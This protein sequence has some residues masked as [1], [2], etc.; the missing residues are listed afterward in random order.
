MAD[1][2]VSDNEIPPVAHD[3]ST[4]GREHEFVHDPV[5][6]AEIVAE[7]AD[8]PDG[9]WLDC[10]LGG[11]G[12]ARAVLEAHGGLRLI[13]LDRDPDALAAAGERLADLGDRAELHRCRFDA[14]DRALDDAGVD[15]LAGFLFDLGVSSPQ[16]DVAERG[17]SFRH[18]GP[19]DMRMDPDG[20]RTA[21]DLV[22]TAD[23]GTLARVLSRYGDERFAGR[24]ASAIIDHRPITRTAE[25]AEI[26]VQAIPAAARRTG[27]HPAKRT[28]QAI[29]IEINDELTVLGP[30]LDAAIDRLDT[31]GR[32]LV[33]TYH[34]GED[35]ITKSVIRDRTTDHTPVGL[36]VR[37][38]PD[39]AALR[40]LAR[41][42]SDDECARNP[43]A[44][45]ARLR[46]LVRTAAVDATEAA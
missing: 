16:L 3:G 24:I 26:V 28:F 15:R 10:T 42:A 45:S 25:L 31:G 12:H 30:A 19:L 27:G 43:R 11:A 18:D 2:R 23:H 37:H 41:K 35:R 7:A 21:A 8:A 20:A 33:L 39:F 34:S 36:A 46:G 32:G 9:V 17:F 14:L 44:R 6:L 4:D 1:Q 5:M 29:R 40:P 38:E 13:G 22:N